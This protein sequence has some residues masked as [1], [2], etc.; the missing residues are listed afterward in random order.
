MFTEALYI[1]GNYSGTTHNKEQILM[2]IKKDLI[3]SVPVHVATNKTRVF[4][5]FEES[6]SI[7]AY[8]LPIEYKAILNL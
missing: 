1:H 4:I 3:I 7:T 5:T 2:D 8:T 6:C